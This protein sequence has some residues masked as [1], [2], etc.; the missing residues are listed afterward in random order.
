M[1]KEGILY[2]ISAP[3]GTGKSTVCKI[4]KE[5]LQGL[6]ISTSHTTRSPR[7]TEK[8]GI[9][10][11]FISKDEFQKKIE[12]NAFLEWAKVHSNFYGTAKETIETLKKFGN[13]ILLELD[14]QG[15]NFLKKVDFEAI[16]IF[17]LPPSFEELKNRLT[18]RSTESPEKIEARIEVG[19]NEIRHYQLYDYIVTNHE[20]EET[21]EAVLSIM[22]AERNRMCRYVPTS[23][24]I[25][26]AVNSQ[27]VKL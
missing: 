5:R 11:F 14:V 27:K 17:I 22:R 24:D 12:Q 20:I 18:K 13:D 6:K 4:L 23:K 9:D 21:V 8:D 2:I 3:S 10:Y 7:P 16:F 1:T 19:K 15:V 25:A 26:T